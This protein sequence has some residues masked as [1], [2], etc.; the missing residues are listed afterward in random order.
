VGHKKFSRNDGAVDLDLVERTGMNLF[1]N[2]DGVGPLR[3]DTVGGFLPAMSRAIVQDPEDPAGGCVS[4][5]SAVLPL[6]QAIKPALAITAS[7][8]P[9]LARI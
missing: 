5:P 4:K 1:V 8:V 2:E 6:G 3:A 9:P 7:K